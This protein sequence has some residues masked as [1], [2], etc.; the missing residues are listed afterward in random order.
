LINKDHIINR[1]L[2]PLCRLDTWSSSHKNCF[3]CSVGP[4]ETEEHIRAKFE[5]YLHWRKLGADVFVEL[6]FKD[7]R[8]DLVIV[9]EDGEIVIE[10]ILHSETTERFNNK[11]D[12]YPFT[13]TKVLVSE[14]LK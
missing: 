14:V 7:S 10:E 8:P 12:R 11:L 13:T 4:S 1:V 6:R 9:K 2:K 3:K 5:R